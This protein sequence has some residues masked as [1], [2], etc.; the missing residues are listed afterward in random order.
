MKPGEAELEMVFLR[1]VEARLKHL[2]SR[3]TSGYSGVPEVLGLQGVLNNRIAEVQ[4]RREDTNDT[5][6]N[7]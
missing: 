6:P 4:K 2:H 3:V 1:D 7:S 5:N